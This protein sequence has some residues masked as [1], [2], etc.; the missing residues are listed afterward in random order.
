MQALKGEA[1]LPRMVE[2]GLIERAQFGIR[3]DVFHMAGHAIGGHVPVDALSGGD[4]G[5]DGLV[6]D[7]ALVGG[8]L[9]SFAVALQAVVQTFEL[10]MSLVEPAWRNEGAQLGGGVC[11]S[12]Q[13]ANDGHEAYSQA[14][15]DR[16]QVSIFRDVRLLG[17]VQALFQYRAA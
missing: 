14:F 1:R 4:S 10:G 6:A 13:Q 7:Q 9:L 2:C 5:R 12:S 17:F 16:D 3:A 15:H 8:H 11:G